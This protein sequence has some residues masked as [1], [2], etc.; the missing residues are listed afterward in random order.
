MQS[1]QNQAGGGGGNP[2]KTQYVQDHVCL[3]HLQVGCVQVGAHGGGG[4]VQVVVVWQVVVES[5][6]GRWER[7]AG[8]GG[9][10]RTSV[11]MLYICHTGKE[12]GLGQAWGMGELERTRY[13]QAG[14]RRGVG[15]CAKKV[16]KRG[17]QAKQVSAM[18]RKVHECA[19]PGMVAARKGSRHSISIR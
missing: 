11:V 16:N 17:R 12:V 15:G 4:G 13:G 2:S 5:A 1:H 7:P 9:E 6:N 8:G 3:Q 14:S 19:Q 10:K 18:P